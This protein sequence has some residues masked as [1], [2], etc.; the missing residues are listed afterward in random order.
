MSSAVIWRP[1]DN[2]NVVLRLSGA[3]LIAGDGL[4]EIYA[5][6]ENPSGIDENILYSVL[7]NIIVTY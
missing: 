7:G 3:A 2:Q 5:F 6:K 4:K 1:F